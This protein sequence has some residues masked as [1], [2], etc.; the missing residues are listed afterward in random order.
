MGNH[1]WG[2]PAPCAVLLALLL[3]TASGVCSQ[4]AVRPFGEPT[5]AQSVSVESSLA[6]AKLNSSFYPW[7][8]GGGESFLGSDGMLSLSQATSSSHVSELRLGLLGGIEKRGPG[9]F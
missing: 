6:A 3:T 8:F 4:A 9:C 7:R 5:S 1:G 2:F